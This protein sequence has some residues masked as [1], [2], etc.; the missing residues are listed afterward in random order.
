IINTN[1]YSKGELLAQRD[2][3]YQ[4]IIQSLHQLIEGLNRL[5]FEVPPSHEVGI[6]DPVLI[7]VAVMFRPASIL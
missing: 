3:I 5:G 1:G 4:N 2:A 7:C 6:P